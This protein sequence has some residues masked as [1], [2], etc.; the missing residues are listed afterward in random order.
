MPMLLKEWVPQDRAAGQEGWRSCLASA[1]PW[2]SSSIPQQTERKWTQNSRTG[3]DLRHGLTLH[4][5]GK[6][7]VTCLMPLELTVEQRLESRSLPPKPAICLWRLKH[8]SSHCPFYARLSGCDLFQSF[9]HSTV[10]IRAVFRN[11]RN[12]GHWVLDLSNPTDK[13]SPE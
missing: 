2:S 5:T 4:W 3:R 7:T 9:I 6:R 12:S 8:T 13:L 11:E 1:H 10:F